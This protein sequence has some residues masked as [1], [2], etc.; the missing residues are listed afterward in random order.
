M[1]KKALI[2]AAGA[3][4]RKLPMQTLVDRN[5]TRRSVLEMLIDEARMAG[6]EEIGVVTYPGD[7]EVYADLVAGDSHVHF[8]EQIN[9]QGYGHAIICGAS[10]IGNDFFLHMVGDHLYVNRTTIP[11]ARHLV[12]VARENHCSVSAVIST[13]ENLIPHFGTIGGKRLHGC[14]LTV[15]FN[16]YGNIVPHWLPSM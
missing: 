11:C 10:F 12:E 8:I 2:T 14:I 3:D 6:I 4:Q 13:R 9:P 5:G 15:D 16:W 1:I 7:S